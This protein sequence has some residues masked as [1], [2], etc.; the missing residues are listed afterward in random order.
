MSTI[1]VCD[2]NVAVAKQYAYDLRRLG[3]HD[4]YVAGSGAAALDVLS[5]DAIDCLVLDLEMPGLDGFGVLQALQ[6]RGSVVPVIVRPV[7]GRDPPRCSRVHRQGGAGR[8]SR[9]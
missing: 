1:L 3:R 4:V 2:D 9:A 5:R 8:A 7:C 6:D